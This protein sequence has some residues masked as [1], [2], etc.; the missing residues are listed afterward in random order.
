M[1]SFAIKDCALIVRTGDQ[2]P[3]VNLRE[4]REII[5]RCS[6]E[7][8]YHHCFET[9]LRPSFD[10][11]E[12]RNDFAVWA[13]HKLHDHTL[14]ERLGLVNVYDFSNLEELRSEILDIIDER[15]HE[16]YT[17]P[18]AARDF[19]FRLQRAVTVVFN[20]HLKIKNLD[21]LPN[22]LKRMTTSSIYYHFLEARR[23]EPKNVDDFT[24]WLSEEKDKDK[25]INQV[26]D[27]IQKIDFNFLNLR[28]LQNQ[29]IQST[30]PIIK[31][32]TSKKASGKL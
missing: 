22:A 27:V 24:F 9:L 2:P 23:R 17:V 20:T 8:I 13:R 28:E 18:W 21:D 6:P 11:P 12:Y 14:A 29:L 15:L 31:T 10:H 30:S 1:K 7:A 16:V 32:S 5:S 3:A 26:I 25:R 4:L 19:E